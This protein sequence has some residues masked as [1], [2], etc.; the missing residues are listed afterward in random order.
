MIFQTPRV[1]QAPA[2]LP[3]WDEGQD[4]TMVSFLTA[5]TKSFSS[6]LVPSNKAYILKLHLD[7]HL[8]K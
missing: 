6:G 8:T 4:R 1:S 5:V 7:L 3:D 2:D